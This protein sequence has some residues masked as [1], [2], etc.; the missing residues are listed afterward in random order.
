VNQTPW[1]AVTSRLGMA[2]IVPTKMLMGI[3]AR[4]HVTTVG[5]SAAQNVNVNM[6]SG[7]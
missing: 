5:F 1:D 7:N 6:R 4:S 2:Q 3:L